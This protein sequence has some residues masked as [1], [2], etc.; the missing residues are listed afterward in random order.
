VKKILVISHERSGTHFLI[1]SIRLNFDY[2]STWIDVHCKDKINPNNAYKNIYKKQIQIFF[3]NNFFKQTDCI[4]KSHHQSYYF[5]NI[6][7]QILQHFHVFYIYRDPK[8]V[9]CSC[10]T[11]F[12]KANVLAFPLNKNIEQFLKIKPYLYPFDGAYSFIKSDNMIERWKTHHESWLKHENQINF[13]TY[14]DLKNNFK[15][16]IKM[17]SNIIGKPLPHKIQVPLLSGICPNKGV[18]NNYKDKLNL[19][20][21]DNINKICNTV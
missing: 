4:Y 17:I 13:I 5:E 15:K 16:Q 20:Q 21:I 14:H 18:E 19:Q 7:Q 10:F 8:D 2:S 1:N 11:Y 12:N 6:L 9:L 3:K